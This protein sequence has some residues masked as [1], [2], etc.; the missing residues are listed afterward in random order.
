[1]KSKKKIL[2]VT[3]YFYPE[4]F[5]SNDIAFDLKNRGYDVTVLTGIPNYP[6]GRYNKGYGLFKRRVE[7]VDGV[8]IYRAFQTPRFNGSGK[9]LAL[10]YL[11]WAF[12]A[13]LWS[14]ILAIFKRYDCIIVHEPSPITQGIPAIL[15]KKL[16]KIPLYFWVLDLW[17]ESLISAGNMHNA[18]ILSLF[19]RLVAW[20]YS[21][22]DKILISSK[23]FRK[24][25]LSKG[26][27]ADKIIYFPNW[28]EDLFTNETVSSIELPDLPEGFT[29]MFAG[30][31]GEAQ[32]FENIMRAALELR[33]IN[34]IKFIIVGDGRK[35]DWVKKF[36][37]THQL[38][39]TCKT[40]GRY[41]LESMPALFKKSD[42]ML[43]TL[44]DELIFNLTVPAKV[45]AYMAAKKP[46]VGMLNG[47]GNELINDISCGIAVNA[48]DYI[49]LAN[50]IVE[51]SKLSLEELSIYGEKGYAYYEQYFTKDKCITHL[52][53][54]IG[55]NENTNNR[56]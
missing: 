11:S 35:L 33:N 4:N 13:S 6:K 18:K 27:F 31:I 49:A 50:A 32:D 19:E 20:T 36:I 51:M 41:P 1:M 38:E 12:C 15:L 16:K 10:N 21:N 53:T 39:N 3:Q 43:V 26:D 24:S 44:K 8:R 9:F 55:T 29:V 54:I 52:E 46:I 40:I 23:G 30:N 17:P 48:G 42:V 37:A 25:I 47:E 34:K 5:K 7:E 14:L 56:N 28:A 22:S 2:L 45:Q